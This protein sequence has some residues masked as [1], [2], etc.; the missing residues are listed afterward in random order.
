LD[1]NK[2]C[3]KEILKLQKNKRNGNDIL[4]SPTDYSESRQFQDK[5][6]YNSIN[7]AAHYTMNS[8]YAT[9]DSNKSLINLHTTENNMR[10]KDASK[11]KTQHYPPRYF[12]KTN[13]LKNPIL[14]KD[15]QHKLNLRQNIIE[16]MNFSPKN[17]QAKGIIINESAH[18]H[19]KTN[20]DTTNNKTYL[21]NSKTNIN[22]S[23]ISLDKNFTIERLK[24]KINKK[25][26]I[27][28]QSKI[29]NKMSVDKSQVRDDKKGTIINISNNI[30]NNFHIMINQPQNNN[31]KSNTN[32]G[33]SLSKISPKLE[34]NN[35]RKI[36]LGDNNLSKSNLRFK[37]NLSSLK[38][39]SNM[40]QKLKNFYPGN[41]SFSKITELKRSKAKNDYFEDESHDIRVKTDLRDNIGLDSKCDQELEEILIKNEFLEKENS[42]RFNR[43]SLDR[44]KK[45]NLNIT[46]EKKEQVIKSQEKKS[47]SEDIFNIYLNE[48]SHKH[49]KREKNKKIILNNKDYSSN[50]SGSN[51]PER[52]NAK[53]QSE[54]GSL[55]SEESIF[56]IPKIK[57]IKIS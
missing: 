48:N 43:E 1:I 23:K 12:K 9:I 11:D 42:S 30:N 15:S 22:I 37:S 36:C 21:D 52:T 17:K 14:E 49:E 50:E 55:L 54:S 16:P 2:I 25:F 28:N 47:V 19:K 45:T 20:N 41:I 33:N 6:K 51:N 5:E 34:L 10:V 56:E 32:L 57:S 4:N 27:L 44:I 3:N 24:N 31:N 46:N 7:R 18:I 8:S 35:T 53:R 40:T 26:T 13:S 29:V 38:E 39:L